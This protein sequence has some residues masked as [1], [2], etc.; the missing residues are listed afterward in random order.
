VGAFHP[1]D[2]MLQ[3]NLWDKINKIKWNLLIVYGVAQEENK[4][5]FLTELSAFYNRSKEPLLIGGDFNIIRYARERN[6]LNGLERHSD[7]FNTLINS[8]ELREI[9][10][11]GGLYTW[12]N[13]Q[14]NPILEKLDRILAFKECE[15]I[16]PNTIVRKLPREISDHNPLILSSGPCKTM[17]HIQSIFENSWLINPDFLPTVRKIWE[18]P[19]RVASALDKIQQKLKM[20]KRYFKGWGFNLQGELRKKRANISDEL[21]DLE[22]LEES[23]NL[24]DDQ[25]IRKMELLRENFS[26]LEQEESYWHNR[27][28]E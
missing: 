8:H 14:E 7:M 17:K 19:C 10:M 21:I 6:R 16:F 12:S 23:G 2:F 18:K 15:D 24:S 25:W 4:I 22:A 1:D 28:R 11:T 20:L 3:M 5:N 27:C 9:V 13:N 26:L